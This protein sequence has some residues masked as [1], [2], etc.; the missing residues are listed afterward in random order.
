[1]KFKKMLGAVA[2]AAALASGAA[3]AAPVTVLG[4]TWDPNA[5]I[6]FLSVGTINETVAV[7]AGQQI[8]GYG[9]ITEIN[10]VST[11]CSGC[12]LTY[13]FSGYTLLNS[14][15]GTLGEAFQFFGGVL[16]I[17]VDNTPNYSASNPSS[18]G[19]GTLW[20]SMVGNTSAFASLG[21]TFNETLI[22]TLTSPSTAALGSIAGQGTG[23]LDVVG[24]AA[25]AYFDTNSQIGGSDFLYT[26][27]FAPRNTPV[28]DG[29]ISYTHSGGISVSGDS[30][31]VPEPGALALLGLGLAGLAAVRRNK[32]V[33]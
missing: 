30:R 11:F 13:T 8:Q 27:T 28:V 31:A 10:D 14:L 22:G 2:A 15:T 32:K 20:L 1:M 24:G 3:H 21:Y 29:A 5:G 33:A 19:N 7:T 4:V 6:D 25:K 17:F 9:R 26:S 12:E 18:A 23:Y 16:D